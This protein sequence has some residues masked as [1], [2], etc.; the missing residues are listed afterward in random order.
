MPRSQV[1]STLGVVEIASVHLEVHMTRYWLIAPFSSQNQQMYENVWRHDLENGRISIGWHEVG[2]ITGL[3]KESV[4]ERVSIIY[5]GKPLATR[6]LYTNMIWN[7]FHAVQPGDIILARKGRKILAGVGTVTRSGYYSPGLNPIVG[8]APRLHPNFMD[9]EWLPTPRDVVFEDIVFP[10]HSLMEIDEAQYLSFTSIEPTSIGATSEA[11]ATEGQGQFA[12]EK[13]LEEFI[14][15]NFKSIFGSALEVFADEDGVH[16]Q[17][18]PTEIGVI[19]ILAWDNSSQSY[20]VI[21]LKRGRPSDQ[22]VGQVLRYMGW[23]KANLCKQGQLVRGLII[24]R[25]SDPRLSYAV[26]MLGNV[27]VK[28]YKVAFEL[29]DDA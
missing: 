20:V 17:Q 3:N 1:S 28:Y 18:Y 25:D 22:V 27:G 12:L 2:D 4:A 5:P 9:V 8:V 11:V 15:T 29:R 16:G 21:E 14:V 13:H 10:M 7:F 23:V 6:S 26:S 24:C 19:D